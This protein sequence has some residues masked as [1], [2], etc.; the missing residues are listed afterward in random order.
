LT[1]LVGEIARLPADQFSLTPYTER[2]AFCVYRSLCERGERAG[3]LED[4][5]EAQQGELPG[6]LQ[7]DF[8]QIA[9]IEF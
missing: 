8:D 1:R 6:D 3:S 5:L 4:E 9:E 7:F 2:C